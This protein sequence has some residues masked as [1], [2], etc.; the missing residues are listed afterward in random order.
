MWKCWGTLF[1]LDPFLKKCSFQLIIKILVFQ[2]AL[3]LCAKKRPFSGTQVFQ[4]KV[5]WSGFGPHNA[6]YYHEWTLVPTRKVLWNRLAY[7][8]ALYSI[9]AI[10]TD[11]WSVYAGVPNKV[12]I[13]L[14]VSN[15]FTHSQSSVWWTV[16]SPHAF[17]WT[18]WSLI[19]ACAEE[20]AFFYMHK[21]TFWT[22]TLKNDGCSPFRGKADLIRRKKGKQG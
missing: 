21:K 15:S 4:K 10:I 16:G 18:T 22:Q 5:Y 13:Y 19:L 17:S 7:M 14:Y 11:Y 6:K 8:H 1:K 3:V 2:I 12:D 20:L 9:L